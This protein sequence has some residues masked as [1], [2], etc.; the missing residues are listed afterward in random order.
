[1]TLTL[2][3]S[4]CVLQREVLSWTPMNVVVYHGSKLAR[5]CLQEHEFSFVDTSTGFRVAAA[6][7]AGLLKFN[8]RMP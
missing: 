1:V 6:E 2:A 5:D 4:S 8:V 3:S 7:D